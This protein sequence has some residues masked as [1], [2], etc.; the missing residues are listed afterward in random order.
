MLHIQIAQLVITNRCN[1]QVLFNI[2]INL[3]ELLRDLTQELI[4]SYAHTS[5]AL[6]RCTGFAF[7]KNLEVAT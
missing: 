3:I 2:F 5:N 7:Q 4:Q 1:Q 6:L